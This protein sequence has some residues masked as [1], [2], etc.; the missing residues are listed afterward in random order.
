MSNNNNNNNNNN[1]SKQK[2]S[3][4]F[5]KDIS[6]NI[7]YELLDNISDDDQPDNSY[8][9]DRII[10]RQL[11]YNNLIEP[12]YIRLKE[13]YYNCK[14]FY[15]ERLVTYK[16]FLTIIRHICQYNN[17]KIV[18]RVIYCNSKYAIQY[19]IDR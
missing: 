16:H 9:I 5:Y 12:F 11:Q 14:R 13:Y 8:R 17:I 1:Q 6:S 18:K 19:F 3:Q 4:I 2:K 10:F 7:L 15:I